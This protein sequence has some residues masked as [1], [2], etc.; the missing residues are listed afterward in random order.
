MQVP[1]Q[2]EVNKEQQQQL[3]QQQQEQQQQEQ[4]QL[5]LLPEQPQ[6]CNTTRENQA[7]QVFVPN[8]PSFSMLRYNDGFMPL[9]LPL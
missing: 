2:E 9:P 3:Q 5:L 4:Q 6:Q 7:M 8:Q 1:I